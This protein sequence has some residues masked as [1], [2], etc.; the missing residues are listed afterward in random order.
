MGRSPTGCAVRHILRG[1]LGCRNASG[2]AF[3]WKFSPVTTVIM[4]DTSQAIYGA[5]SR[6]TIF[7]HTHSHHLGSE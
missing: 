2:D 3:I 4:R 5:G 6:L 7:T 1:G